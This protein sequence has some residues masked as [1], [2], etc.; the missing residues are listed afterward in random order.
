MP[1]TCTKCG[2]ELR[3]HDFK[4]CKFVGEVEIN[5]VP[6]VPAQ[7]WSMNPSIAQLL[8][9]TAITVFFLIGA[10]K[11]AGPTVAPVKSDGG[12]VLSRT[13][14]STNN[15]ELPTRTEDLPSDGDRQVKAISNRFNESQERVLEV[16]ERAALSTNGK[17]SKQ[18]MIDA[19][20][21]F[22]K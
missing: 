6:E 19:M 9:V 20:A 8:V 14:T 15:A 11:S 4:K 7:S 5:K 16:A 17:A 13:A 2:E 22:S 12:V 21:A 18:D 10:Q 1:E 3:Y